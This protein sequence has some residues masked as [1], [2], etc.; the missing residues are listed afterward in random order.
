MAQYELNLRDYLRILRKR[1]L[2][3]ILCP[4]LVMLF[5]YILTPSARPIFKAVSSLKVTQSSSLAGMIMR[6]IIYMPRDTL[7]TQSKLIKSQTT[8]I[9]VAQRL[10]KIR[11]DLTDEKILSDKRN[12]KIINQLS[13]KINAIPA[14]QTSIIEINATASNPQEAILLAN[15][16]AEV[17]VQIS[18]YERNRQAIDSRKFIESQL[19]I[20]QDKLRKAEQELKEF[21]EKGIDNINITEAEINKIY[22]EL[23]EIKSNKEKINQQIVQLER[24]KNSPKGSNIGWISLDADNPPMQTLNAKLLELQL[25][26]QDLLTK[27]T[28]QAPE[29]VEIEEEIQNLLENILSE[30]KQQLTSL[31][32][33]EGFLDR[34][35]KEM[36]D[37]AIR[38]NRFEREVRINEE[39]YSLLKTRYQEALIAEAEK[40]QEID[41]IEKAT[42]AIK[43]HRSKKGSNSLIGLIIGLLLGFVL[44]LI[45]EAMDT[46]IGTIEDVESFLGIPVLGVV[47][48]LDLRQIKD[49]IIESNPTAANNPNI[50]HM[51]NLV[52]LFNTKSPVAEAFR[53]LRT[54]IEF[55]RMQKPGKLF[56]LTSST[57]QE[58]KSSTV[59]NLAISFA[60][61]GKKTLILE[62]DWRR[63]YIYKIFG[64]KVDSGLTD[65]ILGT[66]TIQKATYTFADVFLGQIN[67]QSFTFTPGIDN[68]HIITCGTVPPNPTELLSTNQFDV[69]LEKLKDSYD[70]ILIDSPPVLPVADATILATKAEG[71]SMVYKFGK[72]GRGVLRRAKIHLDNVNANI[73]GIVLN[74]IK[75]EVSG[76]EPESQYIYKYYKEA[77]EEEKKAKLI[78]LKKLWQRKKNKK[79]R[80]KPSKPSKQK[81]E[82]DSELNDLL[83]ITDNS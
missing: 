34:R 14:E 71:T 48:H 74:D 11:E 51:A 4:I 82:E 64:L 56:M 26:K 19:E 55:A 57:L 2:I 6:A 33:T 79:I 63:P 59:A 12:L 21:K 73:M 9:R 49:I 76:F 29:V 32:N 50:N 38:L 43:L 66:S 75:A 70:I 18:T 24:R 42:A 58:G 41:V 81:T 10:G 20:Y 37:K 7:A 28:F 54:N 25:Q 72:I 77:E 36:P 60:Q 47:P 1:K 40:I 83:D 5:S 16:T 78:N 80:I 65:I 30:Y 44:S 27:Y 61:I 68:L 22:S 17:F 35:L 23:Q 69:L 45:V 67:M 31:E 13:S 46:S 15:T 3:V 62:C 53:S 8:M 52:A 39:N